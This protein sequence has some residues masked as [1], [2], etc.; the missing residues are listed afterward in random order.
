MAAKQRLEVTTTTATTTEV[1]LQLHAK[2]M[3]IQRLD[4]RAKLA[5]VVKDAN[6]KPTKKNPAGGRMRRIDQ[7][8]QEIL[9]KEKQGKAL[10]N[11]L[12]L[13]GHTAKLTTGTRSVFDKMGFMKKHGLTQADFDEFTEDVD[14]EPYIKYT[15]P[16]VEDGD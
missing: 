15:H 2:K 6:G 8:I 14:N 5:K 9:K 13:G 12:E 4:E 11:G 10:L 16:G 1:K 7:E 3:L